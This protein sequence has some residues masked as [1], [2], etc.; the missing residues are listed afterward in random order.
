MSRD[1]AWN[2]GTQGVGGVMMKRRED[3]DDDARF[4]IQSKLTK[5]KKKNQGS[6]EGIFV[7]GVGKE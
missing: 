6:V 4:L 2:Q 1:T 7:E 3:D 5:I